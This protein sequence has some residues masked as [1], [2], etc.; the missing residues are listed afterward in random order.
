[1]NAPNITLRKKNSTYLQNKNSPIWLTFLWN[2]PFCNTDL[3][4]FFAIH[5][6][7]SFLCRN[8]IFL[9][10][11]FFC[12][13]LGIVKALHS[14]IRMGS[15][16]YSS[17]LLL[18]WMKMCLF[19]STNFIIWKFILLHFSWYNFS[20]QRCKSLRLTLISNLTTASG[21]SSDFHEILCFFISPF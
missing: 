18:L 21:F 16:K 1:M 4:D 7:L 20:V 10:F 12:S 5:E 2:C 6:I 14:N 13:C 8:H 17:A 3:F 9:A 15:I 19:V 11:S